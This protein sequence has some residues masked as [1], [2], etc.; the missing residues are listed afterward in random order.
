MA[1]ANHSQLV[2]IC[3]NASSHGCVRICVAFQ[4][5]K[6]LRNSITF[7]GLHKTAV[8]FVH[9]SFYL[10]FHLEAT[11]L[12]F[13]LS[14]TCRR[15]TRLVHSNTTGKSMILYRLCIIVVYYIVLCIHIYRKIASLLKLKIT[16]TK[17]FSF[18]S[19]LLSS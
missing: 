3:P 13:W 2:E 5:N 4:P 6:H 18:L 8:V 15:G 10:S 14:S 19:Y 11:M 12:W 1:G 16:E 7:S 9:I 17:N